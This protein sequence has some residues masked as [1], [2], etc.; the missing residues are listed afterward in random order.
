MSVDNKLPV[1]VGEALDEVVREWFDAHPDDDVMWFT[2]N[3]TDVFSPEAD[4]TL[5]HF[6]G[7][8][9]ARLITATRE[10]LADRPVVDHIDISIA[11]DDSPAL[12]TTPTEFMAD[13]VVMRNEMKGY[14]WKQ[15]GEV[16]GF[17][18][19]VRVPDPNYAPPVT[20]TA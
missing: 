18:S 10:W 13:V 1:L 16:D 11:R 9:G 20:G 12:E 17:S 14:I 8:T 2:F 6:P 19:Y 15:V 5:Q 3:R 4:N 7:N